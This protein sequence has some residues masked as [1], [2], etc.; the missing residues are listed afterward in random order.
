MASEIAVSLFVLA[1][2]HH[3]P[4][5]TRSRLHQQSVHAEADERIMGVVSLHIYDNVQGENGYCT[6]QLDDVSKQHGPWGQR[7]GKVS[8]DFEDC[9]ER[10]DERQCDVGGFPASSC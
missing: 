8:A 2:D 4:C 7:L 9:A 3:P 6:D 5:C 1:S 10:H